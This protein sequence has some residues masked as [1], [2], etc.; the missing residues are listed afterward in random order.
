LYG[1]AVLLNV[2]TATEDTGVY[3]GVPVS[4][5]LKELAMFQKR[6]I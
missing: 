2:L 3:F 6:E 4:G 5:M 1:A